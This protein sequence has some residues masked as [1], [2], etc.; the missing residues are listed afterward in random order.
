VTLDK[1]T[2]KRVGAGLFLMGGRLTQGKISE[3]LQK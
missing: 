3:P 1:Y 2:A